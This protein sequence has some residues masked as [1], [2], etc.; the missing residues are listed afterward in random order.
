MKNIIPTDKKLP[1]EH[2]KKKT[3]FF[4]ILYGERLKTECWIEAFI[5]RDIIH[6]LLKRLV[7]EKARSKN[8]VY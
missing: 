4:G 8:H 2:L 3:E 5:S 1:S 7:V 6:F